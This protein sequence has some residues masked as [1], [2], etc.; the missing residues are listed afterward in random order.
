MAQQLADR[1]V[2][3]D[4]ETTGLYS[5]DR[6]VSLGVVELDGSALLRGRLEAELTHLIFDPGKKS[7]PQAEAVHGYD[8]WLLRHQESFQDYVGLL[9]PR[10]EG[11]DII[12]AHNAS[13]DERFIRQEFDG[14]G[15][16]L[17]APAFQCTMQQ[18]R[19]AH[20]GRAGLDAVL[21]KMGLP[22]RGSRHGAL[23][24]AWLAMCVYLWLAGFDHPGLKEEALTKPLNLRDPPP[25]PGLPLPRRS[26]KGKAA[27]PEAIVAKTVKPIW[28]DRE[29][30]SLLSTLMPYS[31]VLM[32]LVW[33]DGHLDQTEIAVIRDLISEERRRLML[34]DDPVAEQ[35]LAASIF[36]MKPSV[37][38]ISALAVTIRTDESLKVR[39]GEWVKRVIAADGIF[40]EIE[41]A[42]L[43][44]IVGAIRGP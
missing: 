1:M 33:A 25:H 36:E 37:K 2:F 32:R 7:H 10:F 21:V 31:T 39:L 9:Q 30:D 41:K 11:A 42:T 44:T 43:R 17:N 3:V 6:V 13:F 15:I 16:V 29:R 18:Y 24:D 8:D 20:E 22:R 19:R 38:D 5:S 27:K 4:V 28:S 26:K 12:V 14:A 23:E 34:P 35:D 40:S